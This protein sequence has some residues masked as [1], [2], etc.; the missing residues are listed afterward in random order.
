M[1]FLYLGLLLTT[2]AM[3]IWRP[4]LLRDVIFAGA[5]AVVNRQGECGSKTDGMHV[6]LPM[7]I[8][9]CYVLAAWLCF[10]CSFLQFSVV[11]K[12]ML[13]F[14]LFDSMLS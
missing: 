4:P 3:S 12:Q 2:E 11:D 8:G 14:F 6:S 13:S 7:R 10:V 9:G 5:F 1:S